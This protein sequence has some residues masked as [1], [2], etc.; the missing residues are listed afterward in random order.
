MS[1]GLDPFNKSVDDSM[2]LERNLSS[3]HLLLFRNRSTI[4]NWG[5]GM[6][7]SNSPNCEGSKNILMMLSIAKYI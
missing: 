7:G 4:L 6:K 5:S 2:K 1:S 3:S